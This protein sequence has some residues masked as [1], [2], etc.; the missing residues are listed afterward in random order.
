MKAAVYRGIGRV[1]MEE[2][3]MPRV[4]EREYL[5]KVL[6]AGLC[7]TDIKTFKQGHHMF[8]PPC[9][10][11]HEFCGVIV[12]AGAQMDASLVGKK[13]SVAPYIGCGHCAQCR[14]GHEELCTSWPRPGTDGAFTE[15][16]TVDAELAKGGMLVLEEDVDPKKMTLAEPFAC[17]LN[18]MEESQVKQGQN[19]L[20]I[21]AG[22]MGL[23]HI[24]GLKL[25]GAG[26]ILV[27]EFSDVRCAVARDMGASVINPGKCE[28]LEA[29]VRDALGG[30]LPDQIFICAGVA[31]AVEQ[32]MTL[33]GPGAVVNIFGGLKSGTTITIDPNIIHYS[34]VK[35]VGTFG[36]SS[37]NFMDSARML[38][39]GQVDMSR[40]ITH[41]FP[42]AQA[43]KAFALGAQPTD[44]V[45][46]ILIE[47]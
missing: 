39:G 24:E 38:A 11:G 43:D 20:I 27:S 2:V 34:E 15:Y 42:L 32:A 45:I 10:L 14:S 12:E 16:L 22:P 19:A 25:R 33:A 3:E 35:L 21:G 47:M 41:V 18:S 26:K 29:A 7:G 40:M 23:L 6:Y 1:S 9:V 28:D 37:E 5:V 36:F 8:T 31:S 17:I 30:A 13:V 44:D 46:K 4:G